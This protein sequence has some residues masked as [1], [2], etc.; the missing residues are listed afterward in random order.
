MVHVEV[1]KR[2]TKRHRN[3]LAYKMYMPVALNLTNL[4]TI[5]L[6]CNIQ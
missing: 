3:A 2:T 6:D 5:L 4:H 1:R